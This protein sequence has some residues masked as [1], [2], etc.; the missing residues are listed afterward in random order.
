MILT[1]VLLGLCRVPHLTVPSDVQVLLFLRLTAPSVFDLCANHQSHC[2]TFSLLI[3]PQRGMDT[4]SLLGWL[5]TQ[6]RYESLQTIR[7]DPAWL[8]I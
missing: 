6:N 7:S 1:F 4:V 5:V 2:T 8:A 3:V